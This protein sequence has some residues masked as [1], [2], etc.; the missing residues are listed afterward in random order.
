MS[1]ERE[2]VYEE[3]GKEMPLQ[4]KSPVQPTSTVLQPEEL[5]D[6]KGSKRPP[7]LCHL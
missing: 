6:N 4:C 7:A 5:Q 2:V 3:M 1:V